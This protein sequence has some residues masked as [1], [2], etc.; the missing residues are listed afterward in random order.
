[1]TMWQMTQPSSS[2]ETS[3]V[4]PGRSTYMLLLTPSPFLRFDIRVFIL[5][6]CILP[7]V[8]WCA[9]LT[10]E[11]CATCCLN[12]MVQFIHILCQ[13]DFTPQLSVV[14]N[15]T[16]THW[17]C[18]CWDERDVW[19]RKPEIPLVAY[20]T[21]HRWSCPLCDSGVLVAAGQSSTCVPLMAIDTV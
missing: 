4:S 1:M 5:L 3:V 8:L 17:L 12:A 15:I 19:F 6:H 13:W 11:K 7:L 2:L 9:V 21:L 10:D 14:N 16:L 18:L 20:H